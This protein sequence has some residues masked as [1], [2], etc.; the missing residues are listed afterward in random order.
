MSG[1][2]QEETKLQKEAIQYR[3]GEGRTAEVLRNV[4]HAIYEKNDW[5]E[6]FTSSN[7]EFK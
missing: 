6:W 2:Y 4:C 3:I 7:R 1:L 5:F